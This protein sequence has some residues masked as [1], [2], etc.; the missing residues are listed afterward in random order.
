[1]DSFLATELRVDVALVKKALDKFFNQNLRFTCDEAKTL[2]ESHGKPSVSPSGVGGKATKDDVKRA[3]GED[4]KGKDATPWNS[5]QAESLAN[6]Q[7]PK[8]TD[9]DFPM[10]KRTGRELKSGYK[11]ISLADVKAKI[12][13]ATGKFS[14]QGVMELATSH[15]LTAKDFPGL[16]TIKKAD[17]NKK[18]SDFPTQGVAK[19]TTAV[20]NLMD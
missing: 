7:T 20:V 11:K 12:G 1:M 19:T 18:I 13:L 9:A 16:T 3:I 15:G 10:D 2:W 14:S 4:T 5:P 8:L 17:V 6:T